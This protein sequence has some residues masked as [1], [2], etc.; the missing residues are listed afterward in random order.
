MR[1]AAGDLFCLSLARRL[2][3]HCRCRADAPFLQS[4]RNAQTAVR[5]IASQGPN[6]AEEPQALSL[7]P[8]RCARKQQLDRSHGRRREEESRG[9]EGVCQG[10][11]RAG[12]RRRVRVLRLRPA[13]VPRRDGG[14]LPLPRV[15]GLPGR[16]RGHG[17]DRHRVGRRARHARPPRGRLP[18]GAVSDAGL[19]R[20]RR[21]SVRFSGRSM[22]FSGRR[23]APPRLGASS[24]LRTTRGR[25]VVATRCV[26]VSTLLRTTRRSRGSVYRRCSRRR[27]V[28]AA[29]RSVDPDASCHGDR[30]APRRAGSRRT[31]STS[32]R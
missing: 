5:A 1:D 14:A 22:R 16:L 23:A 15:R 13:L 11:V 21:G 8:H 12:R 2:A 25:G 7:L 30:T 20:R 4:R 24:L 10:H 18:T 3:H 6:P 27:G 19:R 17:A 28:A 9:G 26:G 32:W 29:A 31:S